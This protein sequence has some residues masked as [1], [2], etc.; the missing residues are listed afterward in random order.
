MALAT[1]APQEALT[2]LERY[3][4]VREYD[5]EGLV[6]YGRA[7]RSLERPDEARAAFLNAVEAVKT[8]PAFRRRELG[9]W[10]REA[11]QELKGTK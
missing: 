8:A 1:G 10:E 3:I 5:P 6:L 2:Y 7:L 4:Q 9:Q 11:R